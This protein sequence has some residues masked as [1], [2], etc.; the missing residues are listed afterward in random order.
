MHFLT[1][2]T[3]CANGKGG[4][5]GQG[6]VNLMVLNPSIKQIFVIK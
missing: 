2:E 5:A 3:V 4:G 6:C 1:H